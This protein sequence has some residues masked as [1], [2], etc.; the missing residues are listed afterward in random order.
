MSYLRPAP[1]PRSHESPALTRG[2]ALGALIREVAESKDI[3]L[4]AL[5][6]GAGISASTVGQI[7]S[8]SI[9]C[10]PRGRLTGIARRLGIP[11]SRLLAAAER[12][13]CEYE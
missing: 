13:G 11:E 12:D 7:M 10:P 9:V 8:G 3:S 2:R 5:A 6:S 4:D 1:D